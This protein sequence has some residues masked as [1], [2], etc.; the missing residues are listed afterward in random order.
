[1]GPQN[2]GFW[3][4]INCS[5]M[6]LPNFVSSSGDGSSKIGHDFSNKVVQKLKLSINIFY[7]K[8]APKLIFFNEIFFQKDSDDF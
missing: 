8:C 3:P 2:Q 6:K 5:Q 7:K 4:K 1:M